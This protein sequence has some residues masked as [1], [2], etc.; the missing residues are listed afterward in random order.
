MGSQAVGLGA[1]S[2]EPEWAVWWLGA[3]TPA[4]TNEDVHLGAA[5]DCGEPVSGALAVTSSEEHRER[6]SRWQH[7]G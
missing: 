4:S 7:L 5:R 6:G 3:T 1:P 2:G